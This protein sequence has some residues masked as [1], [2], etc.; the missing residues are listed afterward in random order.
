[1]F[2]PYLQPDTVILGKNSHKIIYFGISSN[3]TISDLNSNGYKSHIEQY[4]CIP[5]HINPGRTF[6]PMN[7]S[8]I[9]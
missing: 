8:D 2:T 7:K 9:I 5:T 4:T 3:S 1:M 6:I